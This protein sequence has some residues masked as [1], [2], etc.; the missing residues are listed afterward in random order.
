MTETY[1]SDAIRIGD[2]T[3]GGEA[4]VRIQSMANTDTRDTDASVS[5]CIRMI[6]AGAELVRLTT[7]GKSEI[8]ALAE[9]RRTLRE[10]G[11][12][13]PVV[14]DVHY[15]PSVAQA[16]CGAADK[17]RINPGNYLKGG[18]VSDLLPALLQQCRKH[19]TAIRIGVNH[20]SLSPHITEEY[21]N[22]PAGMVESA[23]RFLRVCRDRDF[24]QVTVSMKSSNP[25]VMVQSVRLLVKTMVEEGMRYPLHLGV[26]EAGAGNDGAI[27][28][29]VGIAPLLL[30]GFGDT[31]RVSLTGP[32]ENEMPVARELVRLFPKPSTLPYDPFDRQAWDPFRFNRRQSRPLLT[33]GGG[34][35]VRII[36]EVPPLSGVDLRPERL[37]Q[38]TVSWEEWESDPSQLE[39][40]GKFLLLE[41]GTASIQEVKS[42]LIR[43]CSRNNLAPVVYR[44]R[45]AIHEPETYHLKLAGEL[46]SLLVDGAVDAVWAE[47]GEMDPEAV[48]EVLESILQSAGARISRAEYIACPSCGRTQFDILGRLKEIQAATA[49]LT[50]VKIAVMGCIV[51]GPGEMADAHFGFVGAGRGRITLYKGRTAVQKNI[52]EEEALEALIGLMKTEGVWKEPLTTGKKGS[53]GERRNRTPRN[54]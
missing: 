9:I 11:W 29:A 53:P 37:Q 47:H 43:F 18:T 14:A 15:H 7:Q 20:G 22:T 36:S 3:L 24:R 17:V 5:Q 35:P 38:M 44:T 34:S 28:S 6:T 13:A 23:M 50:G 42:R 31:L 49:H 2:L 1:R 48:N 41:Q 21:G 27:R 32:P 12:K 16:A 33:I 25:R 39:Q 26:T 10:Q 52:P 40:G 8:T 4:P 30:E 19:G 51:N 46:G 45:I 54:G